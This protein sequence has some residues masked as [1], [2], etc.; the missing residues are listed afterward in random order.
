MFP[1]L[2]PILLEGLEWLVCGVVVG[3]IITTMTEPAAAP[4]PPPL[5]TLAPSENGHHPVVLPRIY[6]IVAE[7]RS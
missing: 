6:R 5:L 4:V 7:H 2:I 3:G 1:L